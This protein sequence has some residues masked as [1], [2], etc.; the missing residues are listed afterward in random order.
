M[1]V[2][3]DAEKEFNKTPHPFMIKKI[4]LQSGYGGNIYQQNKGHL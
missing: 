3:L 1:T 2:S 4:S